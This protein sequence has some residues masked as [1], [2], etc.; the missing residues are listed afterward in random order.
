MQIFNTKID[1]SRESEASRNE[2]NEPVYG[3]PVAVYTN[4]PVYMEK[5]ART[6]MY[7]P[8]LVEN[9]KDGI[10]ARDT[11]TIYCPKNWTILVG[12]IIT[13]GSVEYQVK[14]VI[15]TFK[16]HVEIAVEEI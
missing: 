5:R 8:E 12:D 16:S 11:Y 4:V 13:V 2:L 6:M 9:N 7:N 15:N 1:V 10:S 14:S 3:N